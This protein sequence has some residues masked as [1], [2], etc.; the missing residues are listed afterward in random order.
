VRA[1]RP[2]AAADTVKL[3]YGDCKDHALLLHQLLKAAG[4]KSLLALVDT[5]WRLQPA[6][7]SL[8]Q[9]NHMVVH[10]PALGEGWLADATD[11]TLD[12]VRHPAHGLWHAHALLLDPAKPRLLPPPAAIPPGSCEIASRRTVTPAGN[13]WQVEEI[14]TLQG[15]YAGSMR[16]A[17]TGLSG[18]EQSQKAQALLADQGAAQLENFRFEHLNDPAQPAVLHLAYKVRNAIGASGASVPALWEREYLETFFVKDRRTPFELLYPLHITSDVTVKLPAAPVAESLQA[19]KQEG[20]SEFCSWKLES[21]PG[22]K[23]GG[24]EVGLHFEFTTKTGEHPADR[25][26]RSH[27]A[28]E[29]ARS[30]WNRQVAWRSN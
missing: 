7:P 30:A 12:L 23:A 18:E 26:A 14:L 4:V 24:A 29:A 1:R 10:V 19:M 13:D 8:D 11:K 15:Y 6:L 27:D 20:Q 25:Y 22:S 21:T 2:N 17:F 3:R 28:W 16:D 9:F 5:N